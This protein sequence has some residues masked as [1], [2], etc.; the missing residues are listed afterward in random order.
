MGISESPSSETTWSDWNNQG[1]QKWYGHPLSSCKVW[2]R[3][4]S[5]RRRGKQKLSVFVCFV[6]F[7][8]HALDL[9]QRFSHSNSDIFAIC[10]SILMRISASCRGRNALLTFKRH[11]TD[12]TR[13][14]HICLKIR[15]KFEFFWKFKRAQFVRTTSTIYIG[16]G[17]KKNLQQ[18]ISMVSVDVHFIIFFEYLIS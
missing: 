7:F 11:F 8:C 18:P 2:W 3:S 6:C 10:R 16:E 4:A 15:S 14:R 9:E 1:V 5:V 13:W 12:A 17:Q